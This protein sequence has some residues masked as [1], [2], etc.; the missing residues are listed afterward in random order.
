LVG[1]SLLAIAI[2]GLVVKTPIGIYLGL[3]LPTVGA[4]EVRTSPEVEATVKLDGVLRGRAPLRMDG[5][6]AGTR[7]LE[8]EASGFQRAT[9]LVEL[10]GGTTAMV[11]IN[12]TQT[13]P[14]Q[15][16]R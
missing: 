5:V 8:L 1:F 10:S 7:V 3:R 4:I 13:K 12:L 15:P 9:R 2:A 11:E 6:T 14:N 16:A